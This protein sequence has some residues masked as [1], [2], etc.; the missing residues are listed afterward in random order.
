M[1]KQ[2]RENSGLFYRH[3]MRS[4]PFASINFQSH[5]TYSCDIIPPLPYSTLARYYVPAAQNEEQHLA[6]DGHRA[7]LS[8]LSIPAKLIP[9]HAEKIARW[10]VEK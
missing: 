4:S 2:S 3:E 10:K 8:G 6:W 9:L 5:P 1:I 7:S